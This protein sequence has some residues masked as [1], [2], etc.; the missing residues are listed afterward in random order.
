MSRRAITIFGAAGQVGRRLSLVA[1]ARG[2]PVRA[3]ARAECDIAS[4]GDLARAVR[5]SGFAV[6]CAG[7][8]AVDKAES[9][10]DLA[11]AANALAPGLM[12]AACARED[13]PLLH[14]ST[15]YVF[16]SGKD[17]PWREDDP[18]A[19][20]NLYGTTKARG[21]AAVRAALPHHLILRTSWVYDSQGRNFVLTMLRL[22]KERGELRVVGDQHGG[23]TSA[24]DIAGAI[25]RMIERAASPGFEKWGTYHFSGAP[26][27]TW[28]EFAAA[29]FAGRDTPKLTRILAAEYPTPARR[30]LNSVLDCSKVSA[31][32]GIAQPDWHRSLEKVMTEISDAAG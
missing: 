8:T 10:R 2:I 18:V 32:F 19:P 15:D 28:F 5:G 12:A 11:H 16:G 20:L 29:I 9:E 3:L 14:I 1:T 6:N 30:P 17:K 4:P 25:V 26:Q 21:E 23:P 27:T 31:A 13:V 22:G 24:E 7:Y